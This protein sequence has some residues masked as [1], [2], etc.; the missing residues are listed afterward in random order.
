VSRVGCEVTAP[1]D[2]PVGQGQPMHHLQ[3]LV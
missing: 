1:T 3:S 2:G